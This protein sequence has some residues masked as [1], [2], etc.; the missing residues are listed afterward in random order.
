MRSRRIVLAASIFIGCCAVLAG[1]YFFLVPIVFPQPDIAPRIAVIDAAIAGGYLSTARAELLAIRRVPYGD[2]DAL[3]LLK[4][5]FILSREAGDFRLLAVMADRALAS[6][7][8]DPAIR[9]VA[10]YSHIRTGRLADAEAMVRQGLS[11]EAAD[12]VRGETALRRGKAWHGSDSLTREL[13][14]LDTSRQSSDFLAVARQVDDSRLG[15]D[16]A[17]LSLEKGDLEGART[18]AAFSLQ[19]SRFDEPAALIAYDAGD[20]ET[21]IARLN[22]LQASRRSADIALLLADCYHALGR[23]T[24][25][26]DSLR[27]ALALDPK[28]SWTPY[29]DLA[30]DAEEGGNVSQAREIL[31]QGR[32]LFPGSRELVLAA[33]RL[34][35]GQ[36]N[37]T[38]ARALLEALV[39]QRP[40][41]AE[42]AL[43]LLGLRAPGLSSQA[44]RAEMWKLFDRVPSDGKVFLTLASS[45]IASHDWESAGIAIHQHEIAQGADD[46]DSLAIRALVY[47]MQGKESR[48][49]D[50]LAQA[51]G[52][53]GEAR[54]RYDL[55]VLLFRRGDPQEAL[56]QL[57]QAGG[58]APPDI[59]ARFETLKGRCMS[60]TGDIPGARNAFLRAQALDPH[61][62]RPAMEL[63]KLE[64]QGHQ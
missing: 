30:H 27:E 56:S 26:Q 33:A 9:L 23:S 3:R 44:Y 48:A 37:Q 49:V 2:R 64:A 1:A 19:D 62:L 6:R 17:L 20:F 11:G 8:R 35:A 63:R 12:L 34:E 60:A 15:L 58:D 28:V 10:A 61:A 42:A 22:S 43:L 38:S 4:R 55:A 21:A 39:A 45:L 59:R 52:Q 24:E 7:A 54:Y 36:G 29:A 32:A 31:A 50:S 51:V 53:G 40:D 18:L 5:A 13:L 16:A 57:A 14:K 47:A 25:S 41:D 46:P